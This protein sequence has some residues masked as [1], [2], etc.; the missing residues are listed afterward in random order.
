MGGAR[1]HT[2]H[3]AVGMCR[4]NR[5]GRDIGHGTTDRGFATA[6]R[7]GQRKLIADTAI[8]DNST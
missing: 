7:N 6:S 2:H 5:Q 3:L 1:N 4:I 8:D